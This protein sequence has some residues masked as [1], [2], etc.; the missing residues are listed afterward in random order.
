[1]EDL[2]DDLGSHLEAEPM[3]DE[4]AVEEELGSCDMRMVEVL[5]RFLWL[6]H[7]IKGRDD[8]ILV[9]SPTQKGQPSSFDKPSTSSLGTLH[10]ICDSQICLHQ[11][12]S[13]G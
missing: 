7:H 11:N 3:E 1:M 5:V 8:H 2:I 4:V 12:L 6:R 10:K 13:L 9:R